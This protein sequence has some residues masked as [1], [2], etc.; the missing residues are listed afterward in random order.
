VYFMWPICHSF[1]APVVVLPLKS[2]RLEAGEAN[3]ATHW[4]K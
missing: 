4:G 1:G 2:S 3:E